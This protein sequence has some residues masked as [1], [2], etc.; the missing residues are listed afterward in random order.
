MGLL[1]NLKEI[2]GHRLPVA[3]RYSSK[4]LA[5][6]ILEFSP[7]RDCL[8]DGLGHGFRIMRVEE[9]DSLILIF[10]QFSE[11]RDIR[12][13]DGTL[14]LQR[15]QERQAI[16]FMKRRKRHKQGMMIKRLNI[17]TANKAKKM[18]VLGQTFRLHQ[19]QQIAT[20]SLFSRHAELQGPMAMVL[21]KQPERAN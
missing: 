13:N 17:L 7:P 20:L 5:L 21:A 6:S 14:T 19:T 18:D 3:A 8:R 2:L 1:K 11:R 9:K 4:G 15:F 10:E 12:T 16:S